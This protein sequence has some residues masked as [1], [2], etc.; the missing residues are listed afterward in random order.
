MKGKSEGRY[1]VKAVTMGELHTLDL[2]RIISASNSAT[3]SD[4][5]AVLTAPYS[6]DGTVSG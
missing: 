6:G 2:A 5:Q 1:Y 3:V 4:V